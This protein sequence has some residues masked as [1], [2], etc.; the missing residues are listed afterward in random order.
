M[1]NA[2]SGGLAY[3]QGG[4]G[5]GGIGVSVSGN[6][7]AGV[8]GNISSGTLYLAG[9]NN[10]TLSQNGQSLTISGAAQGGVQTGI[11]GLVVSNTTYTSGTV[12]FQNANG[13]SFGSSGANGI[14]ASYTVPTVPALSIGVSGGNTSNTSGTYSGQ[15]V[16]AG[17]NN[18]TLSVSTGAAGAQTITISGANAGGAQTAISGLVV[19]NTTYTSGTVTLQN[20]NGISFGSSGANGISASYTVPAAQTGISGLIVS[21]TTYTSGSVSFSNANGISFGSSAGQAVTASYTQSAQAISAQGGSSTFSTLNFTNSNNVSFSNTGGSIWGSYALNVSAPGGTSN[22]LSGLTFTNSG[23]VSFGLSTGA[24]VGTLS[25]AVATTAAYY[26]GGNTTG[27]SSS[28]TAADQT[29]SI[30]ASGALSGGWTNGSI[31]LSA[32]ATSSLSATGAV[33]L[34]VNGSTISIGAPNYGTLS[35]WDNGIL[36]GSATATQ[37]GVGSVVVQQI[38]LDANLY[39]SAVRQFISNSISSS[40]N[41]SNANT[42]SVQAG[43]YTLNASTLSLLTSGSQSYAFTNTSG[44]S[45]SVL[46]GIKGLTLPL[47]ASLTP[48]NYWLGLW[49]ST[50]SANANWA[51]FSNIVQ[52]EGALTYNGLLGSS[53]AASNQVILGGGIWS[54]TSANLPA[55]MGLSQITGSVGNIAPFVNLY[56]VSA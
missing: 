55:S 49:S 31:V 8:I 53:A 2:S 45:N 1:G 7:T 23:G 10:I 51:T 20:A 50:A 9:G 26:F 32:P 42:I 43:L 11:S 28:S 39:M 22:G 54:T 34:S 29:L 47:A 25:A 24:G 35:Y 41:S 19:S 16:F 38:S 40:S 52:Y 21:N 48:G 18:I 33:S 56:N 14:S 6:N 44:N 27:A 17:G 37:N 30:N 4:T 5:G 15:V 3:I 46:T 13:M 12:T 36:A